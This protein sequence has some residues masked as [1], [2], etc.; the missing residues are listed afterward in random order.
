MKIALIM[1]DPAKGGHSIEML[2]DLLAEALAQQ[3]EITVVH[4]LGW[5]RLGEFRRAVRAA[6]ADVYHISGDVNFVALLLPRGK[7]VLTIHDIDHYRK[8]LRGWRKW[9]Y[10]WLWFDLPLLRVNRV[11]TVSDMTARLVQQELRLR[12]ERLSVI[13]NFISPAFEPAPRD[14]LGDPPVVLQVGTG[15]QKNLPRLIRALSGLSARLVVLGRLSSE[16]QRALEESDVDCTKLVGLTLDDVI[17][18]YRAADIVA[19]A[20]THEGFGLPIV[21]AQVIGRPVITS[22]RPP[23]SDV[24]GEGALLIDP[25]DESAYRDAL[26]RLISDAGLRARL[27]EKGQENARRYTL[28]AAVQD[29]L[30][31][32]LALTARTEATT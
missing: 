20:S 31:L 30:T 7:V 22:N 25:E 10:R 19:F 5:R 4:W 24:A 14:T 2:F 18:Q 8:T 32:Y 15:P 23:M 3:A 16:Q 12:P 17:A 27:V 21:E 9:V 13:P 6:R 11:I 29:H 1:R 28:D 26:A